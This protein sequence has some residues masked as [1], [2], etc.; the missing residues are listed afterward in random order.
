MHLLEIQRTA[1]LSSQSGG[2]AMALW[3]W[4]GSASWAE[5]QQGVIGRRQTGLKEQ[6]RKKA[7]G[8]LRNS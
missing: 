2:S 5:I 1:A 4:S 6:R 7:K 8:H 3:G